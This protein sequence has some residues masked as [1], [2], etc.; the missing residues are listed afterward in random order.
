MN[1]AVSKQFN[2]QEVLLLYYANNISDILWIKSTDIVLASTINRHQDRKNN[3][4]RGKAMH[5]DSC[6]SCCVM[7]TTMTRTEKKKSWS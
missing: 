5:E 6:K 2:F 4:E 1:I 3:S 7:R